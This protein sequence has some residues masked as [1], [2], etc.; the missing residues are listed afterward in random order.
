M[1]EIKEIFRICDLDHDNHISAEEWANFKKLFVDEY[2]SCG[3]DENYKLNVDGLT[4]C[5]NSP[6]F[7]LLIDDLALDT[8][9]A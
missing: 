9:L 4:E 6:I 1:G 3:P 5:F 2:E 7:T 8:D